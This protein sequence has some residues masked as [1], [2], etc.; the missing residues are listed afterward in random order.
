M[1]GAADDMGDPRVE[2]VNDH[3]EVVDGR[4][5]GPGDHEVIHEA[6]LEVTLPTNQVAYSRR[7]LVRD[8]QPHR[9]GALLLAAEALVLTVFSLN[10]CTSPG[11]AVER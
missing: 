7:P 1:I 6:V 11:P 4:S 2:V 10:A 8:A 9:A 3:G 5:V